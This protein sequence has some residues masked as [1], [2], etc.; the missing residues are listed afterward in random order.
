LIRTTPR[1][2]P[3]LANEL[4]F[5]PLIGFRPAGTRTLRAPRET[6]TDGTRL[7]VHA[8]AASPDRSDVVVEWQRKGDPATCPPGSTVLNYAHS[9]PLEHGLA[10]ELAMDA[11]RLNA[12][13]MRRRGFHSSYV[14]IGAV[15]ALT[16]AALPP[17]ARDV[18]LRISEEAREWR[19]PLELV[20]V[21]ANAAALAAEVQR[22]GVTVRATA[23]A[24]VGDEL[25][26]GLEVESAHQIRQV[27]APIPTPVRF[28]NTSE[29]D[30]RERTREHR[31]VFG[32]H[33][34]QITLADD[35]GGR[36]EEVRRLFSSEP[37]Q[38]VPGA[39]FVSRFCVAFDA[40]SA[41]ATRASL[42]VPFIEL[43]DFR[44]TA[45]ADLRTLP[46]DVSLAEYRLRVLAAEPYGDHRKLVLEVLPS[47]GAPRF[48][49]PARVQGS[50]PAFAWERHPVDDAP[51]GHEEIWMTTRV[52]DPPLVTFT[53]V[54]LRVDGPLE[55]AIPLS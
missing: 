30:Q 52:G 41:D 40:P 31:R 19:V 7:M 49:Q 53:G 44:Q 21:P 46:V 16:F 17:G 25:V 15:D 28:A 4:V 1:S 3:A 32:E 42:S 23:V 47:P 48:V 27:G 35:R 38:S 54:V 45:T 5:V 20:D 12:T 33:A 55:L 43:N 36:G 37:Q 51:P 8:A 22:D 26:V 29:V 10:A 34:R 13:T 24:R 39:S 18:E 9:A 14:S 6:A 11:F 2:G 50:D